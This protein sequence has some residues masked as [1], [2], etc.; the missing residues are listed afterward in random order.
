LRNL[1]RPN[2][3]QGKV[4]NHPAIR[5]GSTPQ[6]VA[7]TVKTEAGV[8]TSATQ[9]DILPFNLP[10]LFRPPHQPAPATLDTAAQPTGELQTFGSP[11]LFHPFAHIPST[12]PDIKREEET[13]TAQP[14][15]EPTSPHDDAAMP[16]RQQQVHEDQREPTDNASDII[17]TLIREIKGSGDA[18]RA[19]K[20]SRTV[21]NL[22]HDAQGKAALTPWNGDGLEWHRWTQTFQ[23]AWLACNAGQIGDEHAFLSVLLSKMPARYGQELAEAR[24]ANTLSWE[25]IDMAVSRQNPSLDTQREHAVR[26]LRLHTSNDPGADLQ[27]LTVFQTAWLRLIDQLPAEWTPTRLATTMMDNLPPKCRTRLMDLQKHKDLGDHL[28]ADTITPEMTI[29]C[30]DRNIFSWQGIVQILRWDLQTQ[31]E[32]RLQRSRLNVHGA[33]DVCAATTEAPKQAKVKAKAKANVLAAAVEETPDP[34]EIENLHAI[35]NAAAWKNGGREKFKNSTCGKCGLKGHPTKACG[36]QCARCG[37]RW[38]EASECFV[39]KRPGHWPPRFN[40][41]QK[42]LADRHEYQWGPQG[43]QWKSGK[44]HADVHSQPPA[45][46]GGGGGGGGGAGRGGGGGGDRA[47]GRGDGRDAGRGGRGDGGRGQHRAQS[48]PPANR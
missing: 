46:K 42:G 12:Y 9:A 22:I 2:N 43:V 24:D 39:E 37:I 10:P 1:V 28:L 30:N 13:P 40:R 32:A 7:P 18:H 34:M 27:H 35:T 5:P 21:E 20:P 23:R 38:H 31:Q 4:P 29:N 41:D 26:K 25:L 3:E 44:S 48:N 15:V 45:N 16:V 11:Q 6:A 33:P 17:K 8:P 14:H 36:R 19:P 47:R